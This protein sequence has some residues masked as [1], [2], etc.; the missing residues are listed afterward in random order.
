MDATM[1]DLFTPTI[2]ASGSARPRTIVATY[3]YSDEAGSPLYQTVRYQPKDFRQRLPDGTWHLNGVRRV[4]YRFPEL[5][6][7]PAAPVVVVEG[8]KD[9][10][11]LASLGILATTAAM[12]A[13]K[14][15]PEYADALRGRT[16]YVIPDNDEPGRQHAES[17][18]RSLEDVR[19]VTLPGLR[20]HGDVSDWLDA[21]HDADE[22]RA[23]LEAA[24]LTPPTG[25]LRF[26]TAQELAS[27]SS[28]RTD[29]LIRGFLAAGAITEIDGKIKAAG[30]TTLTLHMVRALLDG[31]PFLEIE[32]RSCRVVYVTEQSRESFSDA[33]RITGLDHRG[34][35][36]L[37]LTRDEIRGTPWPEVAAACRKDGYEVVVFD[38][39][40]KLSG[41]RDENSASEWSQAMN[42]LL[43]LRDNG[44]AV[45]VPRHDRKG[46]GDVGDSGR[47]SS[48]ASGDV[49]IILAL[50]RPEGNQPSNRRVVEALSRYRETP[51]KIVVEL[52]GEGYI[53]LGSDEAVSLNDA[54]DFLSAALGRE[55]RQ[56]GSGLS[57]TALVEQSEGLKRTTLQAAA[58]QMLDAGELSVSGRGVRGDPKVYCLP[59]T[60]AEMLSA[61]TKTYSGRNQFDD[62]AG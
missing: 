36:L 51:E 27:L 18:A 8:E 37:I 24:Q 60:A 50:R 31:M 13:G 5:L 33:L 61:E 55:F 53:L 19:I 57:M 40:G 9:A 25:I 23:I 22:L 39:I 26:R 49:D 52:S 12:G 21:G 29:W 15:R 43:D 4:L 35:E 1:S 6:A 10:D 48:Q 20:E 44:H 38:T 14:W 32:T 42:P 7:A 56:K 45:I 34:E 30:K 16:V 59:D 62:E 58:E 54:R 2:D 41:I 17:I 47:G 3:T 11:R 28:G 46:G